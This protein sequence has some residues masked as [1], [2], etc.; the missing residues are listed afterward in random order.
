M[1]DNFDGV[2]DDES[3]CCLYFFYVRVNLL[4]V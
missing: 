2:F 3:V 1:F 4:F